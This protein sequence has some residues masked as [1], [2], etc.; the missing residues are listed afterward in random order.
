MVLH[1]SSVYLAYLIL[2]ETFAPSVTF[3]YWQR[4]L[5]KIDENWYELLKNRKSEDCWCFLEKSTTIA[6]LIGKKCVTRL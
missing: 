5:S 6:Q 2:F 4:I 1:C 3:K